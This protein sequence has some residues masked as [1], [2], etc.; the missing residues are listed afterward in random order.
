MRDVARHAGVSVRTVSN[1]VNDFPYVAADTR[2]RVQR[3]LAAL[4]YRPNLAA[5][6]LRSGRSGMIGLVLPELDVP[7]FSELARLVIGAA[8]ERNYTIVI[9]QTDGDVEEERRLLLAEGRSNPFDGLIFS[10]LALTG[11]DL[12]QRTSHGPVVL[13]GEHIAAAPFD[14]IAIDNVAAARAAVEHLVAVGRRR[15]AAIGDQPYF[16]GETAQYRTMGY[17]EALTAAGR[18]MDEDLL[19]RTPTFHRADGAA[20]MDRL[21]GLRDPPDAVFCYNDLLAFGAMRTVLSRGLRVPEDVAIVGFDNTEEGRYT[22]P[23]LTTIAPDKERI[24]TLAVETLLARLG[25]GDDPPRK[26]TPPFR[27]EVRES[28]SGSPPP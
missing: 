26:L 10:P 1:V 9:D 7:Y 16:S 2:A 22:T 21:L 12:L 15:I 25:G 23:T 3:S 17:R 19:V 24:A 11:D 8:R 18:P 27:L 14:H 4:G 13:L 6:H 20:A 28:T 5:R